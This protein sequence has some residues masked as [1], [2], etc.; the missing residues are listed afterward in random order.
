MK[1]T[2]VQRRGKNRDRKD[3]RYKGRKKR[4]KGKRR[5]M[6]KREVDRKEGRTSSKSRKTTSEERDYRRNISGMTLQK[7]YKIELGRQ[8]KTKTGI[9]RDKIEEKKK[10]VRK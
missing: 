3:G 7:E 1:K 10:Q 5:G 6:V 2:S 4:G 8:E 9:T